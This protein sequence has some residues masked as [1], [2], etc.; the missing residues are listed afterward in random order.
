[1][2]ELTKGVMLGYAFLEHDEYR[3]YDDVLK[4]SRPRAR[5]GIRLVEAPVGKELLLRG[6][7]E[8]LANSKLQRIHT[9][10][11]SRIPTGTWSGKHDC[12]S[13]LVG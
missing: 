6:E 3:P 9:N 2:E 13:C 4:C 11:D 5:V 10:E 7:P 12:A 8:R 1:M